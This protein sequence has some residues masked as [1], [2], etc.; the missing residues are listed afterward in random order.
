MMVNKFTLDSENSLGFPMLIRDVSI[1][2]SC[3][4]PKKKPWERGQ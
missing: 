4:S 3:S 2:K 1:L